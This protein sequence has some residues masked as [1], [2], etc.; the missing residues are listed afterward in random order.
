M[1]GQQC[2]ASSV[3]VIWRGAQRALT[4]GR[5]LRAAA[6]A[7]PLTVSTFKPRPRSPVVARPEALLRLTPYWSG[8]NDSCA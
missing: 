7:Y 4:A 1:R 2:C 3:H 5:R 6:G 8:Y